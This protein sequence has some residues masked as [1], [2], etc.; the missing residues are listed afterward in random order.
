MNTEY[1]KAIPYLIHWLGCKWIEVYNEWLQDLKKELEEEKANDKK[2][3][4]YYDQL[5]HDLKILYEQ[6]INNLNEVVVSNNYDVIAA[7][8]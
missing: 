6:V 8:Y 4:S 1:F 5:K 7:T 2:E 3:I